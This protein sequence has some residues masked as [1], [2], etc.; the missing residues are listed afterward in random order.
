MC[1]KSLGKINTLTRE[2]VKKGMTL[3]D[4]RMYPI[5]SRL[6]EIEVWTIDDTTKTLKNSYQPILNIKHI[7]QGVKIKNPDD[8]FL[9]LGDNKRVNDLEKLIEDDDIKLSNIHEKINKLKEKKKNKI[10]KENDEDINDDINIQNK[11]NIKLD[12]ISNNEFEVGPA[13]KKT[14]LVVEFLFNP[15]YIS[16]GQKIIINDQNLKA[17]GVITKIFK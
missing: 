6:F 11:K 3:L 8:I 1:I 4:I 9:F 15:E 14:K 7:R 5:A 16:V 13:E 2:N 17:Y 12:N 10:K